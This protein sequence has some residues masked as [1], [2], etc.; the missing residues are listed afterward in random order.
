M[1]GPPGPALVDT[2]CHLS[3]IDAPAEQV[4]AD[5]R[6]AGVQTV[7][8][9]GMGVSGS[10]EAAE[11]ASRLP[12]V[13]ATVGIHPND[14]EEFDKAPDETMGILRQLAGRPRVVGIGETGLDH[15]RERSSPELQERAFRAHI[16]LARETDLALVVHCR[17]AHERLL[18]VLIDAGPPGRVVMHCF[19]GDE[20]FARRCADG[21]FYCSFAG[22]LTYKRNDGLREAARM[23]PAELLLVETDAPF[24]APEGHRGKPN[25]PALLAVTARVLADVR[26]APLAE[27]ADV[28]MGNARRVFGLA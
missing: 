24:L 7:V 10:A 28:L 27:L 1:T 12:S 14:L 17:D 13:F 21:G 23:L 16:D 26:A 19:S 22:N 2:H 15:Y 3:H 20:A 6:E 5:A 11:R 8:D 18:E 4:L 25:A 9:I